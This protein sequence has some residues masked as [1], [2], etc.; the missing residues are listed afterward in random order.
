MANIDVK[1]GEIVVSK[2]SENLIISGIGSCLV[3]TLYEPKLKVGA[4][5]HTMLPYRQTIQKDGG[6]DRP[7]TRYIEVAIDEMIEKML[8]YGAERKKIEAKIIGGA[9]MFPLLG[10]DIGKEN[11]Y[12][13]KVKLKKEGI[14]IVGECIGGIIGRS[15]EFCVASGIVTV[16]TKF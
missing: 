14:K 7:D 12:R 9:N 1:I 16:K 2:N 13:A 8:T 15:V 4:L 3:I 10:E 5:A 6:E 11:V